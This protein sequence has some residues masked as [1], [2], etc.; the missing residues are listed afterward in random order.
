MRHSV[1]TVSSLLCTSGIACDVR[2]ANYGVGL[3]GRSGKA[4]KGLGAG[5][6]N[7]RRAHSADVLCTQ[8]QSSINVAEPFR[9][10]RSLLIFARGALPGP[11]PLYHLQVVARRLDN[12]VANIEPNTLSPDE[13]MAPV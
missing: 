1:K 7:G 12:D 6:K 4:A 13:W 10:P 8:R 2:P 9:T 3:A 11:T 5:V